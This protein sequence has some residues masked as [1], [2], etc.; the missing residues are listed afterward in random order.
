M[1][2]HNLITFTT[3]FHT[4]TQSIELPCATISDTVE[5]NLYERLVEECKHKYHIHEDPT[6]SIEFEYED[7]EKDMIRVSTSHELEVALMRQPQNTLQLTLL[8]LPSTSSSDENTSSSTSSSGSSSSNSNSLVTP[9]MQKEINERKQQRKEYKRKMKRQVRTELRVMEQKRVLKAAKE[10]MIQNNPMKEDS[11]ELTGSEW[12]FNIKRVYIQGGRTIHCC[13]SLHK[14]SREGKQEEAQNLLSAIDSALVEKL[15]SSSQCI[16][17]D[18]RTIFRS[19]DAEAKSAADQLIDIAQSLNNEELEST[20]FV[21]G[22]GGEYKHLKKL[23]AL[24]V[25]PANWISFVQRY[26]MND[27]SCI[28]PESDW[29]LHVI[30]TSNNKT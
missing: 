29:I 18:I 19:N 8:L 7:E 17:C 20:L 9:E 6:V 4:N 28:Q 25:R 24:V 23:N 26:L 30:S 13:K 10:Q 11:I 14:M 1:M 21:C 16:D 22:F 2:H 3:T 5:D 12:S 27:N 15:R